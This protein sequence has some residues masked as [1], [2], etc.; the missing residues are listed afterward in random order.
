MWVIKLGGS[1][2]HDARLPAWLDALAQYGA[3]RVV[4]VPGGGPFA[5]EVRAAQSRW[6]FN[7]LAAHR[8]AVLAMEQY[9]LM[10]QAMCPQLKTASSLDQFET[11]G[12]DE[13]CIWLPA[14]MVLAEQS[15]PASWAVT[16]DSLSAWL[17]RKLG[18]TRLV[19]VKSVRPAGDSV[20]YR[21]MQ[22]L[23]VVDGAFEAFV[24]DDRFASW[25]CGP[26]DSG[27]LVRALRAE[28]D[29]GVRLVGDMA[30]PMA[31]TVS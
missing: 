6:C 17:A 5:D 24:D 28:C 30:H 7:E 3:G 4:I 8:M 1:L 29:P 26:D 10:L 21:A 13:A 2:A 15:L 31:E 23:G 20:S 19:L 9:G 27:R 14:R 22:T 25:L 12:R 11:D 16:S 18:A